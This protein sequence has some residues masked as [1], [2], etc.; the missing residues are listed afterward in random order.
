M[1]N[2]LGAKKSQGGHQLFLT[3]LMTS[4]GYKFIICLGDSDRNSLS[5]S[6]FTS[7]LFAWCL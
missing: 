6:E 5:V 2:S 4:S 1:K 3:A 7:V